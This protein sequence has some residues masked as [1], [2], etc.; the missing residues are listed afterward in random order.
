MTRHVTAMCELVGQQDG[1]K[2][3][4][5]LDVVLKP[6]N[7]DE[8]SSRVEDTVESEDLAPRQTIP[9]GNYTRLPYQFHRQE[10]RVRVVGGRLR[11]GWL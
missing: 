7:V 5:R 10:K 2:Y 3:S 6:V 8:E 1:K 4:V 9:D 11:A